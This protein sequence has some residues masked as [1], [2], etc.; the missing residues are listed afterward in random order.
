MKNATSKK[1][2]VNFNLIFR[3]I[4]MWGNRFFQIISRFLIKI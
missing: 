1:D 2:E 4:I 3:E